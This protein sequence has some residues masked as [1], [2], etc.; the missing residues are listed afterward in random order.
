MKNEE[1]LQI[2]Q[3]TYAGVLADAVL[4]MGREGVLE[5]VTQQKKKEQMLRG[6]MNVEQFG[7]TQPEEVFLILS[8]IFNCASWDIISE[9]DGFSAEAKA[10]KL[11]AFAKKIGAQRPCNLY[12]LD[13]MEGMVKGLD[14]NSNFTVRET[15][16]D[17]QKCKV[18]V[19]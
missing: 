2:L 17:G 6:K 19:Q 1:K 9:P 13:P 7:I 18:E 15:L 5:K 14:D 3:L 12:C 4:Q 8:E 11:C 16:W 10:C